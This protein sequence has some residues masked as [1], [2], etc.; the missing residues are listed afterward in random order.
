MKYKKIFL[1]AVLLLLM[2]AAAHAQTDKFHLDE[3]YEIDE[4]G[5]ILLSSDDANVTIAG[6]NRDEV[7]IDIDYVLDAEGISI[8]DYEPFEMKVW[9]EDGNLY[10]NEQPRE[11]DNVVI[12]DTDEKYTIVIEAPENTS[13]KLRGDDE[14]YEINNID[15]QIRV[16]ADDADITVTNSDS[17]LFAF[18]LDDGTVNIDSGGGVLKLAVDDGDANIKNGSFKTIKIRADDGSFMIRNSAASHGKYK[19]SIDDGTVELY[20]AGRNRSGPVAVAVRTDDG[21]IEIHTN[22]RNNDSFRFKMDDA[23]FEF[24]AESGGGIFF[25]RH[26]DADISS[27]GGYHILANEEDFSKYRLANGDAEIHIRSDDADIDLR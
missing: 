14:N 12:G 13:L 25:I 22:L 18:R 23:H 1:P 27:S 4:N 7:H 2:F 26:D 16:E 20:L 17:R 24:F 5:I 3:T 11:M 19:F 9:V 10:I 21:D 15:G 6:S 8:G